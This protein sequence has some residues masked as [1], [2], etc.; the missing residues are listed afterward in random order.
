MGTTYT[1]TIHINVWKEHTCVRCGRVFRY[2]FK[3]KKT[4]SGATPDKA[5]AAARAAVEKALAHE[6]DLQPCPGCGLYQPDMI[7]NQKARRHRWVVFAALLAV[8]LPL[9][10]YATDLVAGPAAAYLAAALCG[11][12]LLLQWLI[13]RGNPNR[14]L[15]ANHR[16]ALMR[17][18]KGDLWVPKDRQAPAE[19]DEDVTGS[20][21]TR[22]HRTAYLMLSVAVLAFLSPDLVR[23]G[24]GWRANPEWV[25]VV[26]GPGDEPYVYFPDKITSVKGYWRGRP[27]V[28][29]IN[30]QE[31]GLK[32]AV[33]PATSKADSWGNQIQIGSK[34]S[35]TSTNTL[36]LRLR[37]PA[38]ARL[39]G[40]SLD[41]ELNLIA[42]FPELMGVNKWREGSQA[43]RTQRKTLLLSSTGAGAEYRSWWWGGYLGGA[44][45]LVV[46]SIALV[47]LSTNLRRRA[48]PTTI[49]VP[50]T[51]PVENAQ[52]RPGPDQADAP[53]GGMAPQDDLIRGEGHEG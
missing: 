36:W 23:A 5:A 10:L 22:G 47:R 50:D 53:E 30:W 39:E 25:P 28:K 8:A 51:Q 19:V 52:E 21:W 11:I 26:A 2:L 17:V 13:D 44:F 16:L 20:G 1:S 38:D 34:E 27:A 42:D 35:K 6:T 3:R 48:L 12:V 40:K 31:L 15:E 14:D 9:I 24:K 32:N 29:V 46:P 41:L 37:L 33:V 18:E 43:A 7:G 45:L 4:G 49:F